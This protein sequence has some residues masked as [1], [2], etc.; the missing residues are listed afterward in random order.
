MAR[1][2][3][4]ITLALPPKMV[5]KIDKLMK[6]EQRTRSELLQEALRRYI[7]EKEW[8]EILRYGRQKAKEK[9]ITEEKIEEIIDAQRK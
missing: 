8:Q 6:K 3:K 9:G 7:E 2:T 1:T 5:E 4:T